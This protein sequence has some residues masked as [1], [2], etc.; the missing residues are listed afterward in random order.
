MSEQWK[1]FPERRETR[2][3][4]LLIRVKGKQPIKL[5][6]LSDRIIGA[7]THYGNR[8][9]NLCLGEECQWCQK[10]ERPRWKGYIS[11]FSNTSNKRAFIEITEL[12][13]CALR[14]IYE[15]H[16]TLRGT[17]LNFRRARPDDMA[18]LLVSLEMF[19]EDPA[20]LP[21]PLDVMVFLR[22][23]WNLNQIEVQGLIGNHPQIAG[24]VVPPPAG[25]KR[26]NA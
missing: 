10:N 13:G 4:E 16:R 25:R 1:N 22:R 19:V 11:C 14:E 26:K 8:R 5:A 15:T 12:A 21:E 2:A 7:E 17:I 6:C 20:S 9:T 18:P 24:T 23:L 3:A